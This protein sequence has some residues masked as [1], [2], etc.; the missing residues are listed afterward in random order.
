MSLHYIYLG[1]RWNKN[2]D[3]TY[4]YES[5]SFLSSNLFQLTVPAFLMYY[6]IK[7]AYI[8][9]AYVYAM[10]RI[11]RTRKLQNIRQKRICRLRCGLRKTAE[12]P[13]G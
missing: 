8:Y 10:E 1:L 4:I 12:V 5:R 13:V 11:N 9:L 2:F 7:G 3:N 6:A